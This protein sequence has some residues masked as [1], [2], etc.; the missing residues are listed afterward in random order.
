MY[1]GR[2]DEKWIRNHLAFSDFVF[3]AGDRTASRSKTISV[4]WQP[5]VPWPS[6]ENYFWRAI[7]QI[8]DS[9]MPVSQLR[10]RPVTQWPASTRTTHL[11]GIASCSSERKNQANLDLP[12]FLSIPTGRMCTNNIKYKNIKKLKYSYLKNYIA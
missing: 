10:Y 11:W 5:Q 4:K 8:A 12:K 7:S 9:S 1:L 6:E 2:E 3:A